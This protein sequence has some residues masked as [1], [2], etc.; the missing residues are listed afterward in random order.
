MVN[1]RHAG[2]QLEVRRDAAWHKPVL[3]GFELQA[4]A[5]LPCG[6]FGAAEERFEQVAQ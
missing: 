6:A 4:S 3:Q 2:S 5:I 1:S